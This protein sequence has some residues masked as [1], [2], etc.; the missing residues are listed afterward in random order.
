MEID[1]SKVKP[2]KETSKKTKSKEKQPTP[3]L[4]ENNGAIN[5]AQNKILDIV[6]DQ[7]KLINFSGLC[8]LLSNFL[9]LFY[10]QIT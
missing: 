6:A 5:D 7:V 3:L 2:K 9:E 4:M 10:S 1:G 8:L